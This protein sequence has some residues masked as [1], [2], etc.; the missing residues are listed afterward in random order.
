MEP[1]DFALMDWVRSDREGAF[2]TLVG[3]KLGMTRHYIRWDYAPIPSDVMVWSANGGRV[4]F[5]DWRPQKMND[6]FVKWADIAAGTQD[7]YIGSVADDFKTRLGGKKVF[8]TFNHHPKRG[9]Y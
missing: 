3:R 7:S 5:M 2:E 4:P 6:V 9:W 8:L 1:D